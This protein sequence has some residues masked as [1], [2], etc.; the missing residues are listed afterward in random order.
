M[1]TKP[2][3]IKNKTSNTKYW[4]QFKPCT[5]SDL[6]SNP[7]LMTYSTQKTAVFNADIGKSEKILEALSA[8]S[9]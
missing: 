8:F 5:L 7:C 6:L 9:L 4:Y 3:T 1:E 2:V